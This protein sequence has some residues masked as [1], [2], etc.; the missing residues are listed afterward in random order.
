ME[1][2]IV[3]LLDLHTDN[4]PT[5]AHHVISQSP[6]GQTRQTACGM[7]VTQQQRPRGWWVGK[8]SSLPATLPIHCGPWSR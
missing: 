8:P 1:L 6:D 5:C 4:H 7:S 2:E 3:W